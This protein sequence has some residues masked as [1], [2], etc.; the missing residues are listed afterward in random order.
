VDGPICP[1]RKKLSASKYVLLVP[2]SPNL[3][4]PVVDLLGSD[5]VAAH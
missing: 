5:M 1:Q 2:S 3:P 4:D